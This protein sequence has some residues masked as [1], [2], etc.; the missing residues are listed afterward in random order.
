M[1]GDHITQYYLYPFFFKQ[2]ERYRTFTN[3]CN[4]VM[5]HR[6]IQDMNSWVCINF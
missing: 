3:E 4:L 5:L 6:G 2:P 1:L